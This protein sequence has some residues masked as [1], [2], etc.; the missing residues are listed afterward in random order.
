MMYF[1]ASKLASIPQPPTDAVMPKG[2]ETFFNTFIF[3]PL[4]VVLATRSVRRHVSR[5]HRSLIWQVQVGTH[6]KSSIHTAPI[7]ARWGR[8]RSAHSSTEPRLSSWVA[9]PIP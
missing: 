4:A 1:A 7:K 3:I 8:G 9:S 6:R 5:S 2:A